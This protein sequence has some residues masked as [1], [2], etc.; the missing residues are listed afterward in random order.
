MFTLP[1]IG[2]QNS[3]ISQDIEEY[4]NTKENDNNIT[5]DR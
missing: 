2:P 3:S 4:N 5:Y 1:N